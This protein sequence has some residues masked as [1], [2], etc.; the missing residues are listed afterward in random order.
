MGFLLTG[1]FITFPIQRN[2]CCKPMSSNGRRYAPKAFLN[3]LLYKACCFP[4]R[5]DRRFHKP[6]FAVT[7]SVGNQSLSRCPYWKN[8]C[9]VT[10]HIVVL[11]IEIPSA[12]I[13]PSLNGKGWSVAGYLLHSRTAYHL[14]FKPCSDRCATPYRFREV[15]IS[16]S[17]CSSTAD[18]GQP[19]PPYVFPQISCLSYIKTSVGNGG[20]GSPQPRLHPHNQ[21]PIQVLFY[22]INRLV[23]PF[24][25]VHRVPLLFYY[26]RFSHKTQHLNDT[27]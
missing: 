13:L 4:D 19:A 8:L 23:Q 5:L 20:R 14:D 11:H 18:K 21:F 22:K 16:Q 7:S 1:P 15:T 3:P 2:G 9:P 24:Y 12:C 6:F 17:L 27:D 10:P 25:P 26:S